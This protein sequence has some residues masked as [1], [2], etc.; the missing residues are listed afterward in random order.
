MVGSLIYLLITRSDISHAVGM[1]SKFMDAHRSV[2]YATVLQILRYV[3]DT[4]YH[5]LHYSSPS[6]LE[7]LLIQMRTGQVIRLIDALS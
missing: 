4:L 7:L 5:G 6:S 1:V 3:K 2:H